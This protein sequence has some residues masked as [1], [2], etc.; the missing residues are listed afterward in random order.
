[1]RQELTILGRQLRFLEQIGPA[2]ES[3]PQSLLAAPTSHSSVIS[4]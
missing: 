2:R 4:G 1:M 3:A